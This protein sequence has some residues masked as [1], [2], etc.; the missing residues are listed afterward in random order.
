MTRL[1]DNG[2]TPFGT[3]KKLINEQ[4]VYFADENLFDVFT[5]KVVQGNQRPHSLTLFR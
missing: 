1:L 2:I 3:K 4:H 5:V